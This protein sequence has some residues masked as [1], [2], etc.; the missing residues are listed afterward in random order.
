MGFSFHKRGIKHYAKEKPQ[1][2]SDSCYFLRK[3]REYRTAGFQ[4]VYLDETWVNQNHKPEFGWFLKDESVLPQVPA[5]K[6]QTFVILHAGCRTQGLLPGCN[7]VFKAY[8]SEGDYHKEMNSKVFLE[9]WTATIMSP[10]T[11]HLKWLMLKG[12]L[13]NLLRE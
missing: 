5:G 8:S 2:I 10:E 3:I 6:G 7:L 9:W 4:I 11:T 1:I 13:T 12:L